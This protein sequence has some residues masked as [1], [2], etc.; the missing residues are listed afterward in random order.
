MLL[1]RQSNKGLGEQALQLNQKLLCGLNCLRM[2]RRAAAMHSLQ[3]SWQRPHLAA[4]AN[5][6][7]AQ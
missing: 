4:S 6:V 2:Y 7:E 3:A 5:S 1:L